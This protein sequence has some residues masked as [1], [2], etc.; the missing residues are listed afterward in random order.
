ME[1]IE[2][3][4]FEMIAANGSARSYFM[5]AIEAAKEGNFEEAEKLMEEGEKMLAEGHHAHGGLLTQEA[6]GDKV[7]VDLLLV[8]AEDQMMAAETFRIMAKEIID[9]HKKLS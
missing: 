7:K 4:C 3:V 1:G 2:L 9:I 6:S 8:H 5:E